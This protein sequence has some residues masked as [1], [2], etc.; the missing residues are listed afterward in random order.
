LL[1]LLSVHACF[2]SSFH[3]DS[4][5]N[6]PLR[7]DT[8]CSVPKALPR[9]VVT[10]RLRCISPSRHS[11]PR[12]CP[13]V[14]LTPPFMCPTPA[15]SG[16]VHAPGPYYDPIPVSA[17]APACALPPPRPPPPPPSQPHPRLAASAPA[18]RHRRPR[19]RIRPFPCPRPRPATKTDACIT[20]SS[21]LLVPSSPATVPAPDPRRCHCLHRRLRPC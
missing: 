18:R 17:P 9:F 2:I 15:L 21:R 5:F 4:V 14:T 7:C 1:F 20:P 13:S 19:P 3:L 12:P 6:R 8:L 16:P 10:D 11:A